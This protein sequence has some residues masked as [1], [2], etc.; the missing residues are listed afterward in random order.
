MVVLGTNR[1]SSVIGAWCQDF[2]TYAGRA[3]RQHSCSQKLLHLKH[4]Q[5]DCYSGATP[6][7]QKQKKTAAEAE[8]LPGI[9]S[10]VS[11]SRQEGIAGMV[12]AVTAHQR[13]RELQDIALLRQFLTGSLTACRLSAPSGEAKENAGGGAGSWSKASIWEWCW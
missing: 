12:V 9:C 7:N 2:G 3:R 13:Y 4:P 10:H 1:K 5:W 8:P 6:P 11:R